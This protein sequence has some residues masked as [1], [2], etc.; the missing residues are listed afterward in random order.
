MSI[1][2]L[3]PK[4]ETVDWLLWYNR[5]ECIPHSIP[6]AQSSTNKNGCSSSLRSR[7]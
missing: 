1:V 4:D 6:S 3:F 2:P 7:Q 5:A